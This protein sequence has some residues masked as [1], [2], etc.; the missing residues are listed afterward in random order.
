M[1]NIRSGQRGSF[2]PLLHLTYVLQ[3]LSDELL[4]SK[5]GIG[6]SQARIMSVLSPDSAMSQRAAAFYLNQTEANISRQ[7]KAMK[8]AG[9]VKITKNKQDGRRRDVILTSKGQSRY[10][11]ALKILKKQQSE[12]MKLLNQGEAEMLDYAVQKLSKRL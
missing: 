8:Q 1:A 4:S 12:F 6:L 5:V 10:D 2:P 3:H 7:L 9:L 11:K